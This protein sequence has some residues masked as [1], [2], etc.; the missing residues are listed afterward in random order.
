MTAVLPIVGFGSADVATAPALLA[1]AHGSSDPRA[2]ETL[3]RLV[4]R[5]SRLLP[6]VDVRIS[7]VDHVD[8]SV[9]RALR[10]VADSG[11]PAVVLPLLLSAASHSK[12][13]IAGTVRMVRRERPTLRVSY[14]NVLGPHPLLLSAVA[15]SLTAAGVSPDAAVVLAAAGSADPDANADVARTARLL[16]EWRQG[17]PVEVAF[18]TH[19]RPSIPEALDRL[20]RLGYDAAAGQIAVASYF[21]APG[22]LPDLVA[23]MAADVGP[24]PVTAPLA[25]SDLVAE[26]VVE[27]YRA[28]AQ[29]MATIN[30]DSCVHRVPWPGR[31]SKVGAEQHPHTHPSD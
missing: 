26:L 2:S 12:G 23:G 17:G 7:Y 31:E 3:D 4:E 11:R 10:F 18:A 24:V 1:V 16:F 28:A 13:D 19:T 20:R 15:A 21:L 5:V 14:G 8:P 9:S 30:C 29:G 22:K 25:D 6:G 27:R